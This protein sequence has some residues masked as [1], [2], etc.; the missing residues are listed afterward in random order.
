MEVKEKLITNVKLR[1]EAF[2]YDTRRYETADFDLIAVK[3]RESSSTL[4]ALLMKVLGNIDALT[5]RQAGVLHKLSGALSYLACVVGLRSRCGRLEEG[6]IYFRFG[7]PSFTP[8][9]L[10]RVVEGRTSVIRFRGGLFMSIDPERLK[11]ARMRAGLSQSQ[12][13]RLVGVSKKNVYEHEKRIKPARVEVVKRMEAILGERITIGQVSPRPL[14][15]YGAPRL[16]RDVRFVD[17][18]LKRL[19]FSTLPLASRLLE[20]LASY[21]VNVFTSIASR[22]EAEMKAEEIAK[23]TDQ[24]GEKTLLVTESKL[25]EKYGVPS[26]TFEEISK[27]STAKELLELLSS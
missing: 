24:T 20:L 1:L 17:E 16:D 5:E 10:E 4:P 18:N 11:R 9:T 2:G 3:R 6:V 19:G 7:I 27:L 14:V 12:L 22:R 15:N 23:F 13:A 26:L 21:E 8:N 25:G